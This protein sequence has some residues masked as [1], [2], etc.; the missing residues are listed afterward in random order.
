MEVNFKFYKGIVDFDFLKK[1][2]I[3]GRLKDSK[4]FAKLFRIDEK[5]PFKIENFNINIF[6]DFNIEQ[7]TWIQLIIFLKTGNIPYLYTNKTN[8]LILNNIMELSTKLGGIPFLDEFYKN[9]YLEKMKNIKKYNPQNPDEDYKIL[10]DWKI[11][12]DI[13]FM[14]F[15]N[16]NNDYE[17]CRI[18]R[19]KETSVTEYVYFR[20]LKD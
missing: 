20:K 10:Y 19:I 7:K 15:Q 8:D 2:Y 14:I 11:V 3:N 5:T 1:S 18:F 9:Y 6:K 16:Q 12:K 17:A 4:V 13:N